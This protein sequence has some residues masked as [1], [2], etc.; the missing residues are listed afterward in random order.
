MIWSI[1]ESF[2][3]LKTRQGLLG[4]DSGP[5]NEEKVKT[6]MKVHVLMTDWDR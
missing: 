3:F 6:C 4:Y 2:F 5:Q 1:E